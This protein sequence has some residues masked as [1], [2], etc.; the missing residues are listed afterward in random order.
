MT[1]QGNG[2]PIRY[3]VDYSG[4]LK[5][6]IKDLHHRAAEQGKGQQFVDALLIIL[7]RLSDDPHNVGE[8]LFHYHFLNSVFHH[9]I[10]PPLVVEFIINQNQHLVVLRAL[11]LL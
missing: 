4:N 8:P 3:K 10:F 11:K 6:T 9:A 7:E 5:K 1:S 2:Q